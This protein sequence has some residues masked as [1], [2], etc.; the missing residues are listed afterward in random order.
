MERGVLVL[1]ALLGACSRDPRCREA[2]PAFELDVG[3][4]SAIGAQV[5]RLR[6]E[7]SVKSSRT[8]SR[9]YDEPTSLLAD[10][11]TSLEVVLGESERGGFTVYIFAAA[12]SGSGD[13]LAR[14]NGTF[15]GS[16]D[17]CNRFAL[18]LAGLDAQVPFDAGGPDRRH[19]LWR[20]GDRSVPDLKPKKDGGSKPDLP[21]DQYK[22]CGGAYQPCCVA[23]PVCAG[24]LMCF[25]GVC[26]QCG[27]AGQPCCPAAPLCGSYLIC[28]SG[29]CQVCG[30]PSQ[31]CCSGGLCVA[32]HKCLAGTCKPADG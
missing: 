2:S 10:G 4:S 3:V 20:A 16:G 13:L 17:A 1:L 27:N 14:G 5:A 6:V 7:L 28:S 23:A 12:Y 22:A 19:D 32:R 30:Y 25:V 29:A 11:E 15:A 8:A 9:T 21:H 18:A 24:S 31:P 26:M